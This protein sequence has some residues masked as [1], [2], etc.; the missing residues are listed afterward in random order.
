MTPH[1]TEA[2]LHDL[3]SAKSN[4]AATPAQ[5]H[6]ADCMQCQDDFAS[7]EQSLA[8]F[9]VAATNYA[10]LNTPPRPAIGRSAHRSFFAVRRIV[11]ATGLASVLA[12]TGV[13][14]STLHKQAPP[15]TPPVPTAAA[16]QPV[17]DEALLQ[18]IDSD[19]STSVPPSLEPLDTTTTA[20][21]QT[22]TSTSN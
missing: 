2:Q 18:D 8:N 21:E 10:L 6:L 12:V 19:L 22:T 3:L 9:R 4:A 13:T 15:S 5:L 7:L 14:L 16:Q 17:S 20:S 1:L 11:W